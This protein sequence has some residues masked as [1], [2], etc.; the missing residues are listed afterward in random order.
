MLM[1]KG[2]ELTDVHVV[3]GPKLIPPL[4][5]VIRVKILLKFL[6]LVYCTTTGFG[7]SLNHYV[8]TSKIN[9]VMGSS[10]KSSMLL[11]HTDTQ[12]K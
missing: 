6:S 2:E 11:T 12:K 4:P 5:L 7:R 8:Y 3:F 1:L 10:Q 9:L